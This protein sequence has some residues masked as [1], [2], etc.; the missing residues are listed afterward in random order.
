MPHLLSAHRHDSPLTT[1]TIERTG[2]PLATTLDIAMDSRSR[3]KGLLGRDSLDPGHA[4]VIAPCQGIHTF[5]MRF[6][7]DVVAVTRD[8]TVV[9]TRA[10]VRPNRIV[11]AWS[12]FAIIELRANSLRE[13]DLMIGDQV[14][15]R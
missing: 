13:S 15:F 11:M 12:A 10:N 2:E 1:L 4:F 6:P 3:K 8:G 7:I 14:S 5:G 9:K